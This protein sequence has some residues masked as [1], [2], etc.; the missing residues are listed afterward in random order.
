MLPPYATVE[1]SKLRGVGSVARWLHEP[2]DLF[3][4]S[5]DR[6]GD[7]PRPLSTVCKDTVDFR[8]VVHQTAA[9]GPS[10]STQTSASACL[11]LENCWPPKS[12]NTAAG[13]VSAM[14]A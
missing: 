1:Q 8:F 13:L 10:R 3:D 14:A 9:I 2:D 11:K 6:L 4:I 5:H 7:G 12:D